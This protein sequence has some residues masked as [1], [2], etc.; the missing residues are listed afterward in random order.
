MN[1]TF[2]DPSDAAS[3]VVRLGGNF[4][5]KCHPPFGKPP[6]ITRWIAPTGDVVAAVG[7]VHAEG[8]TLRVIE[9]NAKVD[10]GRYSCK[11]ENLAGS[12]EVFFDLTV[13]GIDLRYTR[14]ETR[15]YNSPGKVAEC[16]CQ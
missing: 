16:E 3:H 7:R 10:A 14:I 2:L 13:A 4:E 6:P 1:S 12:R 15:S 11:A 5:I 8:R 9:A